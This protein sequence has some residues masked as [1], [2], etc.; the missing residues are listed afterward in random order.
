L[1]EVQRQYF[2]NKQTMS[3]KE[4]IFYIRKFILVAFSVFS[5]SII[6]GYFFTQSF[7]MQTEM[8]L[9]ELMQKFEPVI[10]MS[11]LEQ[12]LVIFLNNSLIAFAGILLGLIFAVVPLIILFSNGFLLGVMFNFVQS[13]AGWPTFFALILPH[14]IIEIPTAVLACAAGLKLGKTVFNKIFN[15]EGSIKK[16]LNYALVFFLKFLFPLLAIAAIIETFFINQFL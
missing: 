3:F 13:A 8:L 4:Y 14:G 12:F 6:F 10:K 9:E 7:P 1:V 15:K 11:P 2:K 16:E 5:F